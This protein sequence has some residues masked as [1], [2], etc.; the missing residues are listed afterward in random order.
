MKSGTLTIILAAAIAG[1]LV[2]ALRNKISEWF[3]S[4]DEK[5]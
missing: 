2:Y 5:V 3:G 4:T 1:L